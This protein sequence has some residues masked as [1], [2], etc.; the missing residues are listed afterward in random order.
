MAAPTSPAPITICDETMTTPQTVPSVRTLPPPVHRLLSQSLLAPIHVG[1]VSPRR[2]GRRR[3]VWPPQ[4]L[5]NQFSQHAPETDSRDQ[6]RPHRITRDTTTASAPNVSPARTPQ[7]THTATA[8]HQDG[9]IPNMVGQSSSSSS[10]SSSS[11]NID[12]SAYRSSPYRTSPGSSSAFSL[13]VG[14]TLCRVTA[15]PNNATTATTTPTTASFWS[16]LIGAPKATAK[17]IAAVTAPV[18][19]AGSFL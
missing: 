2:C 1:A 15:P 9:I 11:A 4:G 14:L 6:R 19:N 17:A 18:S 10:S 5:D 7:A 16:P 13:R 3:L 8:D 12:S